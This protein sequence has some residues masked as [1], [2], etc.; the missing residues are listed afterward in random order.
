MYS[1]ATLG[2]SVGGRAGMNA[3]CEARGGFALEDNGNDHPDEPFKFIHPKKKRKTL[4]ANKQQEKKGTFTYILDPLLPS[5]LKKYSIAP[6][7]SGF[8]K[9]WEAA[10]EKTARTG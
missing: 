7:S 5:P 1:S 2:G 6:F 4:N 9:S 10:E 8:G 3:R